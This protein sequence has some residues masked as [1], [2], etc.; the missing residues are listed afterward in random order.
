MRFAQKSD[1]CTS[2][3]WT[4][5]TNVHK[6]DFERILM[7]FKL[8]VHKS[9]LERLLRFSMFKLHLRGFGG[10]CI[11]CEGES[12]SDIFTCRLRDPSGTLSGPEA[13][14]KSSNYLHGDPG[15]LPKDSY[16]FTSRLRDPSGTLPAQKP[17]E[18]KG[19]CSC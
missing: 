13:F 10:S 1:L 9:D 6:S 15:T 14:L 5:K 7:F 4:P 12:R 11:R 2:N 19:Y 16:L 3:T 18:I 8:D 17:S